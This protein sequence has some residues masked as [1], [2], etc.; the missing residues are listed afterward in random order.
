MNQPP[1]ASA[2]PDQ[3]TQ[4]LLT[5]SFNGSGSTDPDGT[6]VTYAWN[7]G[8]GGSGSGAVSSHA[9]AS[10]GTYTATLTVTDNRGGTNTDSASVSVANRPPT[11]MA[12]P[13]R[14]AAPGGAVAFDGSASSDADGSIRTYAWAFGDGA[15]ASGIAMNHAYATA[16]V[17]SAMLTV[18]DDL[19]AVSSDVATVTVGGA[20]TA[21]TKGF[22]STGSDAAYAVA[23]DAAGNTVVG[24]AYRGAMPIGTV[25]TLAN[26]GNADMF[27][28]KY[29]PDGT[30]LWARGFGSTGDESLLGVAIDPLT[31]NVVAT[32]W[33]TAALTLGGTTLTPSGPQDMLLAKFDGATGAP[34]WAK[35]FGG[36]YEDS[37]AGVAVDGG[38][39][40]VL[41]GFFKGYCSFGGATLRTAQITDPDVF[42]AKF[43][44]AGAH[45][46]S[47]RFTNGAG[48]WG[49]GVAVDASGNIALVGAFTGS[50][51]LGGTALFAAGGFSDG[52]VARF[53]AAGTHTWSRKIGAGTPVD[54]TDTA[55]AVAMDS[56][57]NVVVTGTVS[58]AIDF[59]GG[60]LSSIG[61][62]DGFA[63]MYAATTGTHVW[64]RTLGGIYDD[65]GYGIAVDGSNNVVVTGAFTGTANFG[66]ATNL[67]APGTFTTNA[68]VA[69]YTQTGA[70]QWARGFGGSSDDSGRAIAAAPTG[71]VA[72]AGIFREYVV[73]DGVGLTNAGLGDGF[74]YHGAP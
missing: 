39:N 8:D 66:G 34:V 59:G 46:W 50:L 67:V 31:G 36:V 21:W 17:Y 19:G 40:I 70:F 6:I 44:S 27:L 16:G 4:T 14:T 48:D 56:S 29:A 5:I 23:V 2:G 30:V 12:G 51:N 18:T 52:F 37:G 60:V 11:A 57:G 26:A 28:V 33:F 45:L 22:S 64:S 65:Y 25:T 53:D 32:G 74:L 54:G 20:A 58:G 42:L 15:T 55:N 68:F 43:T 24:G 63:A 13:D 35:Q 72:V 10:A 41:T 9:Y 47:E 69:K 1:H 61:Q 38:G 7:F 3:A 71:H 62:F 73:F 49:N